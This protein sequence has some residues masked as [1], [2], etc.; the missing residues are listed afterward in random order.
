MKRDQN[1]SVIAEGF[2]IFVTNMYLV[3]CIR[4]KRN[5]TSKWIANFK[6]VWNE[7]KNIGSGP[8][9]NLTM[10]LVWQSKIHF[11]I[12]KQIDETSRFIRVRRLSEWKRSYQMIPNV[13]DKLI[14]LKSAE[15][16]TIIVFEGPLSNTFQKNFSLSLKLTDS[17]SVMLI[18]QSFARSIFF[19]LKEYFFVSI[20]KE[21]D[22][23][24]H[25]QL[26]WKKKKM[27]SRNECFTK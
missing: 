17:L 27:F 13:R 12:W 21:W 3:I 25:N 10:S 2:L 4:S 26:K 16:I 24:D 11:I 18:W 1:S 9:M 5:K 19:N 15:L 6:I 14:P 23:L 7:Q 8:N 22:T 20:F